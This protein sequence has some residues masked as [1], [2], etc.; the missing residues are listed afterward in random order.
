M[1]NKIEVIL[2]S[3][4]LKKLLFSRIPDFHEKHNLKK[5]EVDIL[6]FLKNSDDMDTSS[7]I[8]R[9]LRLNKGHVSQAMECLVKND[10]VTAKP[11]SNDR[12]YIHYSLTNKALDAVDML[13]QAWISIRDRVFE[14]IS[15]KE[16]IQY[17]QISDRIERN[18]E[19]VL[20]DY[21]E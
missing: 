12:R 20:D 6:F 19:S 7:D 11:D 4:K 13:M 9:E 14:G 2:R 16:I 15:D 21:T 5:I 17:K 8:C 3:S 18:I 1:E 10:Y